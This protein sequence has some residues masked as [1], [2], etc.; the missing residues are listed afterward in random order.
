MMTTFW[1][2]LHAQLRRYG[3]NRKPADHMRSLESLLRT[4]TQAHPKRKPSQHVSSMLKEHHESTRILLIEL[5]H[6][7]W[8]MD[9]P[10]TMPDVLWLRV[11]TVTM[12]KLRSIGF[13]TRR[14]E[15][16]RNRRRGNPRL[17]VLVGPEAVLQ[18]VIA[19]R[20]QQAIRTWQRQLLQWVT[21]SSRLP[22]HFGR[23]DKRRCSRLSL[24]SNKK[25]TQANL[26]GCG[27][28]SNSPDLRAQERHE[29]TLQTKR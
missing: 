11:V 12:P 17:L 2:I 5:W 22:T 25:A 3:A 21:V 16:L 28:H 10:L 4:K 19:G 20:L 7:L 15:N 8:T 27:K 13:W 9:S 26:S 14:I 1:E 23:P 29:Q 6:N 24:I 18:E